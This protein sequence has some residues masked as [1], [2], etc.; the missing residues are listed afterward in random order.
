[1][2]NETGVWICHSCSYISALA[3]ILFFLNTF[4][5]LRMLHYRKGWYMYGR[6]I[7]CLQTYFLSFVSGLIS[8]SHAQHAFSVTESP[9]CL[10]L[11]SCQQHKNTPTLTLSSASAPAVSGIMSHTTV[12]RQ[13]HLL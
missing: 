6:R 7:K 3:G 12:I 8:S 4:Y 1:M 9:S 13:I 2:L 11:K 10:H 5:Q